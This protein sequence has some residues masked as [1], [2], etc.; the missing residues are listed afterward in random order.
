M[1]FHFLI[2]KTTKGKLIYRVNVSIRKDIAIYQ[3][4]NIC[5]IETGLAHVKHITEG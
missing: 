4:T 1:R 2:C 3:V 5:K